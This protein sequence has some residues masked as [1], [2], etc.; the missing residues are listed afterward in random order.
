MFLA[1]VR[2][3]LGLTKQLLCAVSPFIGWEERGGGRNIN[4]SNEC[5]QLTCP[6]LPLPRKCAIAPSCALQQQQQQQSDKT[7]IRTTEMDGVQ[8]INCRSLPKYAIVTF[9]YMLD[10]RKPITWYVTSA[11]QKRGVA[12]VARAHPGHAPFSY[13]YS[14]HTVRSA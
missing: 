11:E 6:S 4:A 14:I 5:H 8:S 3:R 13:E 10:K 12:V 1:L 2:S 7:A 9:S